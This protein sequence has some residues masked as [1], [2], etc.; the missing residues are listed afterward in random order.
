MIL[1]KYHISINLVY[2]NIQFQFVLCALLRP[3]SDIQNFIF[4]SLLLWIIFF[5]TF[6]LLKQDG[7]IE[8]IHNRVVLQV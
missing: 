3:Q 2:R 6:I 4:I 8:Y 7:H 5:F 1:A